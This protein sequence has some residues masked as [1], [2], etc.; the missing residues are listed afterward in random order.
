M[1]QII[2]YL[3]T[4]IIGTLF[5]SFFTLAIYRIPLQQNITHKRSYC[6]NCRHKLSF[7]DMIP[8]LSYILL[9][10]KCKYC[11]QKIR[12]R[13]LFLEVMTGILFLIFAISLNFNFN[14]LEQSKFVYLLFGLLYIAGLILIAGIDKEKH[15]IRKSLILYEVII[16]SLY[17]IYLY[18]VEQTNI[19]RYVIYLLLIGMFFLL[20]NVLLKK[21]LK[22]YY[23]LE[24]IELS[25][26]ISM[27]TY[28]IEFILTT[29]IT[30]LIIV[31]GKV[32]KW[33]KG[34]MNKVAKKDES[35]YENLPIGCYLCLANIFIILIINW[36][37]CRG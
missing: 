6:P 29:I 1:E 23:P 14:I 26:I 8:I 5:G 33:I 20:E 22:D 21:K 27:F 31:M 12:I 4:F 37:A 35:Y 24:V 30:L 10:G 18:T 3:L 36:L 25:I 11:K 7:W 16:I 17:M 28:E 2:F 15:E 9:K 19:Y 34:T 32:V 13:Y